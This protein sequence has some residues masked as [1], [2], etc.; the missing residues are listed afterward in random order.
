MIP[1]GFF[2][3]VQPGATLVT[4]AN[5]SGS[6][7][8]STLGARGVLA[9]DLLLII[10]RDPC[11]PAVSSGS[12]WHAL[13]PLNSGGV[14]N[15]RVFWVAAAS[16]DLAGTITAT[17]GNGFVFAAYR[18]ANSIG[19]EG[20]VTQ[21]TNNP[22]SITGFSP[23]GNTVGLIGVRSSANS[24]NTNDFNLPTTWTKRQSAGFGSPIFSL[25]I[26]DRLYPANQVYTPQTAI[27]ITNTGA[28]TVGAGVLS[29]RS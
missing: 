24:S 26:Y 18:G 11:T 4:S 20:V 15:G 12:T 27:T 2:P 22:L 21:N 7:L 9:G 10:T 19:L 13:G 16:G 14:G 6:S 25:G 3:A 29:L 17:T 8:S 5:T 23:N 1:F 28:E